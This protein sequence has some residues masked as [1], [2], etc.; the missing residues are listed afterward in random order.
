VT[1]IDESAV[2]DYRGLL[3]LDGRAGMVVGAG[4][5]MGRQAAHALAQVGVSVLCV[6]VESDRAD[7]VAREISGVACV[8]DARERADVQ[9]MVDTAADRLGGL[10]VVIDVVGMARWSELTSTTDE[11]W[12]WTFGMVL[13][14][15][16]L[17]TQIAG[18]YMADHRGGSM[19]FIGSVS[20]LSSAPLHAPYGAA[21]AGLLSLVRTAAVE[22]GPSGVRV[23]A[24]V[25]G[26]VRTPRILAQQAERGGPPRPAL[27]PLGKAAE[28]SDI[29]SAALF[30]S[31]DLANHI[32]GHS[33]VVDGGATANFVYP[34]SQLPAPS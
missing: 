26:G 7:A 33:L 24:V 17:L 13:R 5:G 6:D 28:T 23:N 3:D 10:D 4:Q 30:L 14:H 12:E 32:T 8:A 20:A 15:A 34:V 29:A 9:R 2:P 27:E 25:P 18:R 11:D 19:T 16:Q 22:L 31:S 1:S 21:K